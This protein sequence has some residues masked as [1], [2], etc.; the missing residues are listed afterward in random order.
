MAHKRHS[1][2]L[3][4]LGVELCLDEWQHRLGPDK[5]GDSVPHCGHGPLLLFE[6]FYAD[7][8]PRKFWACAAYRDRK[9]CPAFCWDGDANRIKST[10]DNVKL[11]WREENVATAAT[12][13]D[14]DMNT[15]KT[16]EFVVPSK[17][18]RPL[19]RNKANAQ[20]LFDDN[21]MK[22]IL[23]LARQHQHW[24]FLCIGTPRLHDFIQE[25][26]KCKKNSK[27][28]SYLLDMDARYGE[29]YSAE[30]FSRFNMFN[31]HF[32][33]SDFEA[34]KYI[35]EMCD[36]VVTD[37]PFGGVIDALA[38]TLK[39]VGDIRC[40]HDEASGIAGTAMTTMINGEFPTLFVFPYFSEKAV[41]AT[42]KHMHMTDYVVNYV[43][44]SVYND[45]KAKR[46]SAVRVYSNMPPEKIVMPQTEGYRFCKICRR[47]IHRFNEHCNICNI[48]PS[49]DGRRYKHCNL[50]GQCVKPNRQHC[51]TC[52]RCQPTGHTCQ[53]P[54]DRSPTSCH[55]CGEGGHRRR[56]CPLRRE[57]W[58]VQPQEI[59]KTD[60]SLTTANM[61]IESAQSTWEGWRVVCLDT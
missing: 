2:D 42:F 32:W 44:H 46:Q 59:E 39:W 9:G 53:S 1:D 6:R 7:S 49:K 23:S 54:G 60:I 31:Q 50:C 11:A 18:F 12:G 45:F 8:P 40:K 15:S 26:R 34:K 27:F 38:H 3:N 25:Q 14:D 5:L 20:Y 13:S 58:D 24:N 28:N 57:T 16:K 43:N 36:I 41:L 30:H 35:R 17:L 22:F 51:A 48:C 55:L 33:A 21:T 10:A 56:D 4:D 29:F 37:P 52:N 61:D 19:T 47:F